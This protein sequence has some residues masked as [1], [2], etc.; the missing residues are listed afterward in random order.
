MTSNFRS[1]KNVGVILTFK[2]LV[3]LARRIEFCPYKHFKVPFGGFWSPFCGAVEAGETLEQAACREV[4][5]ETGLV[6]DENKL[7]I[8]SRIRDLSLFEYSL[9]KR[10][11]INLD[12]E[13]TEYGYFQSQYIDT[14]PIPMDEEIIN[15][16]KTL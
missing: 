12:Y 8:L 14:L 13:H 4:L 6:I 11:D 7:K 1:A 5:E 3:I 9:D 2:E 15:I 16:I 10:E